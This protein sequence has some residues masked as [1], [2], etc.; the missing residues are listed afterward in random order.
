MVLMS[1]IHLGN[2]ALSRIRQ[3]FL[4]LPGGQRMVD[5]EISQRINHLVENDHLSVDEGERLLHLLLRQDTTSSPDDTASEH[6]T[7]PNRRDIIRLQKQIDALSEAIE[8]L[9]HQR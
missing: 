6:T 8:Q 9:G 2:D 7:M 1:L 4:S 5:T 3:V